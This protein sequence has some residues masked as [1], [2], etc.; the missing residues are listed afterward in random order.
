MKVSPDGFSCSCQ[1]RLPQQVALT[2]FK[3][4]VNAQVK[5][6]V[7]TFMRYFQIVS[8]SIKLKRGFWN[9]KHLQDY[10]TAT[11]QLYD[12]LCYK[13]RSNQVKILTYAIFF[14]IIQVNLCSIFTDV[15]PWQWMFFHTLPFLRLMVATPFASHLGFQKVSMVLVMV[16]NDLWLVHT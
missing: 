9:L 12:N 5:V 15:S 4:Q 16:F 13:Y 7:L 2:V 11:P 3:D 8:F 14:N 10:L 6:V 1:S